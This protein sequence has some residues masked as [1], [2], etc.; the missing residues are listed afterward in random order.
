MI[1][2]T[3]Q[4][5][6]CELS[7]HAE[8]VL[9]TKTSSIHYFGQMYARKEGMRMLHDWAQN[10]V[11]NRDENML[12]CDSKIVVVVVAVA[13]EDLC[14]SEA[15]HRVVTTLVQPHIHWIISVAD[16]GTGR[17]CGTCCDSC[18]RRYGHFGTVATFETVVSSYQ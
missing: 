9:T 12:Y 16:I 15:P 11:P 4:D 7:S 8:M 17:D 5:Q 3:L 2:R 18:Q 14:N 10:D 13:L 6:Y 1:H